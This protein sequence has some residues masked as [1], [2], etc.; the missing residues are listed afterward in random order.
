VSRELRTW[1]DMAL[2]L[3]FGATGLLSGWIG[4]GRWNGLAWAFITL[5]SGMALGSYIDRKA[6]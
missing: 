2:P 3:I 1:R 4:E 5:A 6:E